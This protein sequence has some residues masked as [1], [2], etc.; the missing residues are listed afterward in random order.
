VAAEYA[1]DVWNPEDPKGDFWVRL[2]TADQLV[3]AEFHGVLYGTG[4]GSISIHGDH[5]DTQYLQRRAWVQVIRTDTTPDRYLG[6]FFLEQGDFRAV[7]RKEG[8]GRIL[9]FSGRGGLSILERF[10]LGHSIYAPGQSRRGTFD[11]PGKWHWEGEPYGAMLVR[12]IEEGKHHPH[13]PYAPIA[14]GFTRARDSDNLV[15]DELAD[16]E[17][18]IGTD[19]LKLYAD[20]MRLGLV[21]QMTADLLLLVSR[22]VE[23]FGTDRS[24]ASF[25]S[26]KVRFQAGA[27]IA[28][29]LPKRIAAS[30]ERTFVLIEDRTGDYQTVDEDIDGNP[31]TGVE[32]GKFLKSSTTAD[33]AAIEKIGKLHLTS[34]RKQGDQCQIQHLIGPGGA[35]GADGY[36]PGPAGDY[37][38][39]DLVTVHTGTA[40]HDYDEQT[41]EVAG[42]RI[43]LNDG[44]WMAEVELGAQ[45]MEPSTEAVGDKIS[46]VIRDGTP[47]RLCQPGAEV[48]V[49]GIAATRLYFTGHEAGGSANASNGEDAPTPGISVEWDQDEA[50]QNHWMLNAAYQNSWSSTIWSDTDNPAPRNIYLGSFLYELG[51]DLLSI[52]Q[53]GGGL[54]RAQM[55]TRARYGVG[56]SEGAQDHVAQ[57]GLRVVDSSGTPIGT[58]LTLGSNG[59]SAGST[60]FPAQATLV[61]RVFP[62]AAEADVLDPVPSAV[63]GDY[64]VVEVGARH[65]GPTTGGTGAALEAGGASDLGSNESDTSGRGWI[66]ISLPG[67]SSTYVGDGR[68]ELVGTSTSVKRCDDTE[69]WHEVGSGS[70]NADDDGLAGFRVGTLW[71]ND[72][73]GAWLLADASAGAAVWVQ[74]V[75]T[76]G[77][78]GGGLTIET[79]LR[80]S[81]AQ[82]IATATDTALTWDTEMSDAGAMHAGGAPTRITVG[83]AQAG[84]VLRLMCQISVVNVAAQWQIWIRKNG[85]TELGRRFRHVGSTIGITTATIDQVVGGLVATDYLEIMVR[86]ASGSSRDVSSATADANNFLQVVSG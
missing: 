61:N 74:L 1:F 33:D 69:H 43:F 13:S 63:A 76:G 71:V 81:T 5:A 14:Y 42:Y 18:P 46:S 16:Y 54:V 86:Q 62:A 22:S 10:P 44:N 45:Y 25:A 80:H 20:F 41:I 35:S 59:S 34:L 73:G 51:G 38:V 57:I 64:L 82:S 27:N 60:K 85:S 9:T 37:D 50:L 56:I 28:N 68:V 12:V 47:I 24:S 32:A 23:D 26:G 36:D 6:G 58:A 70:P 75:G 4:E 67:S 66:D 17:T 29:E 19:G 30:R 21:A 72:D 11:V 55:R 49:E 7:S 2:T 8:A 65:F 83:A 77:G 78:G 31:L 40:E 39:G 53:A 79:E 3:D 48:E 84:K 15:W 52:I